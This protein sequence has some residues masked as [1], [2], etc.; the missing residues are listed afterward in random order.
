MVGGRFSA[1]VWERLSLSHPLGPGTPVWGKGRPQKGLPQDA[2]PRECQ[3]VREH[4]MGLI[5]LPSAAQIQTALRHK[6]EIEHHRNKI[7]LRAK[8]RGHYDFP[9]VDDLSSGDTR[10]RHRVYR[11]AQMQI[12]KI[13]DPTASVPSVFIE[14][15]KRW[16]SAEGDPRGLPC[17]GA[18]R[19]APAGPP[20]ILLLLLQGPQNRAPGFILPPRFQLVGHG[21]HP[22]SDASA[23]ASL[24]REAPSPPTPP[25]APIPSRPS[26][27]HPSSAGAGALLSQG[28]LPRLGALVFTPA[29]KAHVCAVITA[30]VCVL[31]CST[32]V[33][34]LVSCNRRGP[35]SPFWLLSTIQRCRQNCPSL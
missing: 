32:P 18:H 29:P 1:P 24:T 31:L 19:L 34:V 16:A 28:C 11:R 14:P 20:R 6:S 2:V 35:A 10:E 22:L 30:L 33:M 7:R 4:S 21:S 12:D 13:L 9:V 23:L 5:S 26:P 27:G 25:S 8:R 15:R 3:H 17:G